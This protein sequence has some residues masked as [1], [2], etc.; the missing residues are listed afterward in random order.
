MNLLCGS[1]AIT[2]AFQGDLET[3]VYLVFG[4]LLFDFADGFVAR[5]LKVSGPLGA[6]LDSLADLIT[7]G[8][9][10]SVLVF[11]VLQ[12][13]YCDGRCTGIVPPS[14]FPY[15]AFIIVIFSAYRLAKFNID[16][17]QSYHFKG[18]PT[19]INALV[20]CSIPFLLDDPLLGEYISNPRIL[21]AFTV[22]QS[23][24]LVSDRPF[25]ALKFRD[26]SF[27][28]NWNKYALLVVSVFSL[29]IFQFAGILI[30]YGVYLLL[31]L[32]TI[33]TQ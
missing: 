11:Q 4:G 19:P 15:L 18:I 3:G 2:F 25:L 5:L 13:P 27:N 12:N 32:F 23:Y 7:F 1:L 20:F 21:V 10:P 22:I 24:L 28:N 31:S 30:I 29:L 9:F 14:I 8:L 16:T 17:E 26:Y 6:Q 33:R